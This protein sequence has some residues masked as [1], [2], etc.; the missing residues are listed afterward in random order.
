MT[1]S[2][3]LINPIAM[4]A[5]GSLMGTPASIMASVPATDRRHRGRPIGFQNLRHNPQRVWEH[6]L[7]WDN[8]LQRPFSQGAVPDFTSTG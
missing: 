2:P 8:G 7:V 6:I 5:T 1:S 4:P 3:S